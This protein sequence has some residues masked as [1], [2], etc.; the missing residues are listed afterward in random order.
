M[1][2]SP[3]TRA[4][5]VKRYP[6]LIVEVMSSSTEHRTHKFQD[7]QNLNSSE[8]YV[9]IAQDKMLVECHHRVE[10]NAGPRWKAIS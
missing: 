1:P 6:K 9:L 4:G 5:Y 7:Y 8:E 2:L 10:D 3:A